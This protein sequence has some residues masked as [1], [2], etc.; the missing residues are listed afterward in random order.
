[1]IGEPQA[2][3]GAEFRIGDPERSRVDNLEVASGRS[4]FDCVVRT[5]SS[6]EEQGAIQLQDIGIGNGQLAAIADT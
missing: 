1:M 5:K 4:G 3:D 2:A 6:A